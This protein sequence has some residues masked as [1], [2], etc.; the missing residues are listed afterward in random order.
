MGSGSGSP[1]KAETEPSISPLRRVTLEGGW[2][3]SAAKEW[4]LDIDI[5]HTIFSVFRLDRQ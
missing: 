1:A 2:E 4:D 3:W 5:F